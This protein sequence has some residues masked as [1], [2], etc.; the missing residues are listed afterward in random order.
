M[1]YGR[2]RQKMQE[3]KKIKQKKKYNIYTQRDE[4][5]PQKNRCS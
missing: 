1:K 2:N 4:T 5:Y 3:H